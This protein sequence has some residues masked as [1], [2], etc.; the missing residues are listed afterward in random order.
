[1]RSLL[2]QLSLILP[3]EAR[4]RFILATAGSV[5]VGLL[6]SAGL[7]L[8]LPL[9]DLAN[10]QEASSAVLRHISNALG[11][12]STE[13]LTLVLAA[14]VV[15]LFVLKDLGALWFTWWLAGYVATERVRTS[16]RILQHMLNAPYGNVASRSSS[17]MMRTMDSAVLQV[18][19]MTINGLM[20]TVSSTISVLSV[21][22]VLLVVAPVPTCV[23]VVY[24]GL[25]SLAFDRFARPR[26]KAAGAEG[27]AASVRGFRAAF[28]A[29]GAIKELKLRGTQQHF[30]DN[31]RDAQLKGARASRIASFISTLPKYLLEILFIVAVGIVIALGSSGETQSGGAIGMLALFV[32]AG[33]R[34]LPAISSLLSSVSSIRVGSDSLRIVH[35]E[36]LASGIS[37]IAIQVQPRP[38]TVK[39]VRFNKEISLEEVVFRYQATKVDVL[40]GVSLKVPRGSSLAL[41]GGSGAGKTTLV[42]VM[43]G[44]L[45][46][47]SGRILVDGTDIAA[48]I[49]GWQRSVAYVAQEAFL[50]EA[51]LAENVAFDQAPELI[52]RDLV[53]EVLTAAQLL[54]VVVALPDGIDSQVGERG[55]RLS[56]G[57]RQRIGIARALYRRCEVLVLDEAT[58]A[59][60]NE[61]EHRVNSTIAELHGQVTLIVIAHR[62]STVRHIDQ[63][64]YLDRGRVAATGSFDEVRRTNESFARLVELGSLDELP[65]TAGL[66][67]DSALDG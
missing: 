3:H 54:D 41:V 53:L 33:F 14:A 40:A 42:D 15:L 21:L 66:P 37:D 26:A 47:T 64:V 25:A 13:T 4:R 9:V 29:L 16:A 36:V 45:R 27:N 17:E 35:A 12:P 58:A 39:P 62:L 56:G 7:L 19:T 22:V 60:D 67:P 65:N 63:I 49:P 24:F 10:G 52:D 23:L 50:L 59:L 55:A 51:S 2:S 43:V 28:A 11:N 8:I 34:M 1:M 18:F 57:Q 30:V 44:L 48:N 6:D 61:T 32:A 20:L 38:E 5:A 46:P 31:Y